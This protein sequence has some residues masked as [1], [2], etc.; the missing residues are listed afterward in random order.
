MLFPLPA[1]VGYGDL[2]H[3]GRLTVDALPGLSQNLKRMVNQ[4][5]YLVPTIGTEMVNFTRGLVNLPK[6]SLPYIEELMV[7]VLAE[8][9]EA[10]GRVAL[11][12]DWV[13]I[14]GMPPGMPRAE[15]AYLLR[16]ELSPLEVIEAGTR[17]AAAVCGQGNSLGVL[18]PGLLADLLVLDGDPL[19]DLGAF[20]QVVAVVKNG[21]IVKSKDQA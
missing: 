17:H 20:D 14:P 13:G 1:R 5:V 6:D 16:A 18:A 10:G 9:I 7:R 4:G 15:M 19:R 12:S 21:R 11:G 2:C 3:A 8:F